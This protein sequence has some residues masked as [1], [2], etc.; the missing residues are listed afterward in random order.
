MIKKVTTG[1]FF[2]STYIYDV[3]I[4]FFIYIMTCASEDSKNLEAIGRLT[5]F[6][7]VGIVYIIIVI[8]LFPTDEN[9]F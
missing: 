3:I 4:L 1:F 7:A 8:I 9:L 6:S 5:D 2:L